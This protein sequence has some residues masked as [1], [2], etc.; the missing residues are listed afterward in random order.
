M[1]IKNYQKIE[2]PTQFVVLICGSFSFQHKLK[3]F[4]KESQVHVTEAPSQLWP[5]SGGT[6]PAA[7]GGT[8]PALKNETFP[9][10][11]NGIFLALKGLCKV[12]P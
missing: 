12:Q 3:I 1:A 6:S 4:S 8:F 2:L 5:Q 10:L 7:K 11:K 9:A